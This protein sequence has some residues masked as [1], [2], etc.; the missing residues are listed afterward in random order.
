MTYANMIRLLSYKK[1]EVS[2]PKIN[3]DKMLFSDSHNISN[4]IGKKKH[5]IF[6]SLLFLQW[7]RFVLIDIQ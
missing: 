3:Y 1:N 4:K 5:N 6:E 7:N 2:K